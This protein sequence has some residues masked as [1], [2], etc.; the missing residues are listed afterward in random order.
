MPREPL[1]GRGIFVRSELK[2]YNHENLSKRQS[3]KIETI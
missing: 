1:V 3:Q 2:R